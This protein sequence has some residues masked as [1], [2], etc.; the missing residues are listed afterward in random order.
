VSLTTLPPQKNS[1]YISLSLFPELL[2]KLY[3]MKERKERQ[4]LKYKERKK[5]KGKKERKE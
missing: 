2:L 3:S 5:E 1:T 4:K